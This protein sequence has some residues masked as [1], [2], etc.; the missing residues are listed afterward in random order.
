MALIQC[1]VCHKEISDKA[2]HCPH[3]GCPINTNKKAIIKIVYICFGLLL[4][5]G[6]VFVVSK[7][8]DKEKETEAIVNCFEELNKYPRKPNNYD[9]VTYYILGY[10]GYELINDDYLIEIR[11]INTRDKMNGVPYQQSHINKEWDTKY[12]YFFKKKD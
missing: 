11:L 2:K 4:A 1:V 3:C 9:E 10:M 8:S 5:I 7:Q 6:L 12:K